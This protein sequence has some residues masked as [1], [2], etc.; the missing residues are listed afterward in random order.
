MPRLNECK[1]KTEEE[2]KVAKREATRRF[3]LSN[4]E[5]SKNYQ[6]TYRGRRRDLRGSIRNW[7]TDIKA[8]KG[9]TT[10]SEKHPACLDF[11]HRDPSQKK[12]T[13]GNAARKV[14]SREIILEEMS[15]CDLICANCHRKLHS[16]PYPRKAAT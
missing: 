7:I 13:I 15:K 2:R 9:C 4:P 10:C 6:K 5:Y 8:A 3:R 12:F 1:Y 16:H 14:G 11:H